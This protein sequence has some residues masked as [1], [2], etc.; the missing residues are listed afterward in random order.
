MHIGN[1][2]TTTKPSRY[3]GHTTKDYN[4]TMA[5]PVLSKRQQRLLHA[6]SKALD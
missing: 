5:A 4:S 6:S 1:M 3:I 2:I